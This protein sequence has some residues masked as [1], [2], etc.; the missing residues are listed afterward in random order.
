[1]SHV[2]AV[3]SANDENIRHSVIIVLSH[4]WRR[5]V[6]RRLVKIKEA[7][8]AWILKAEIKGPHYLDTN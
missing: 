2:E 6:L 1:L 8:G 3:Q 7:Q 5:V 4:C